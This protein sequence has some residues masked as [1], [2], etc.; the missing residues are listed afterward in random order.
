VSFLDQRNNT[1]MENP[2]N[3]INE[4]GNM[5]EPEPANEYLELEDIS[6]LTNEIHL[7]EQE[8]DAVFFNVGDR[9]WSFSDTEKIELDW[10]RY[11]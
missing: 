4:L 9:S 3:F 7:N 1:V 11:V 10:S 8:F 5:V 2:Y 6:N